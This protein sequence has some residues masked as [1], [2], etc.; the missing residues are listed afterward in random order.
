MR[1][2]KPDEDDWK[3]LKQVL[4]YHWGTVDDKLILGCVDVG[5]TKLFVDAA[6]AVHQD[7]KSHTGGGV[8]WEIGILLSMCQKQKLNTS[9][10]EAEI[11][12]I[13]DFVPN[14]IWARMFLEA[15][16]YEIDKNLLYQ[17]NQSVIKIEKNGAKSC[18]KRSTRHIDMRYY[19]I[20]DR[21]EN[22]KVIFCPTEYMVADFFTKPLQGKLFHYL[23]AIVM[24]HQ[25]IENLT[26]QFQSLQQEHVGG[27][28][29]VT[30]HSVSLCLRNLNRRNN[31]PKG[32]RNMVQDKSVP[33]DEDKENKRSYAN[34]V[35]GNR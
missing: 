3:K 6:F 9:S 13:S 32:V 2:S 16:G 12:G 24:G 30:R 21:L 15:Q 22:V 29:K 18:S 20:K 35:K 26:S 7:T 23:K 33:N 4:Q 28:D 19:F 11:V 25:P 27:N 1:V 31:N 10:M 14:V 17:D 5:K 8:S 34:V